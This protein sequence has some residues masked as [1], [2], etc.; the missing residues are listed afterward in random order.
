MQIIKISEKDNVYHKDYQS[1]E[2]IHSEDHK[3]VE[4]IYHENGQTRKSLKIILKI[5]EVHTDNEGE[6][7]L[8]E[9]ILRVALCVNLGFTKVVI[10]VLKLKKLVFG[11]A[12]ETFKKLLE[13]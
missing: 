2:N 8:K 5:Y 11:K 3:T 12:V 1:S 4:N 9:N 7:T 10:N 13:Q 6:V